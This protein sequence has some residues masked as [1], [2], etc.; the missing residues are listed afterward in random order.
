MWA[1]FSL[2]RK[3]LLLT[4]GGILLMGIA[5]LVYLT[6]SVAA[7]LRGELE[8]RG[9]TIANELA[10]RVQKPIID[11]DELTLMELV[12]ETKQISPD[13]AYVFILGPDNKPLA[14]TFEKFP[15]ELINKNPL[16]KGQPYRIE[17]IKTEAGIVRDVAVP[18]IG[19]ALG[20]VRLGLSE[21]VVRRTFM[22]TFFVILG[23]TVVLLI[24]GGIVSF[25][26]SRGITRPILHL[27]EAVNR[28]SL[29]ETD[30]PIEVKSKDEIGQLAEA[31]KR[32]QA[33]L[34]VAIKYLEERK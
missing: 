19:G 11:G 29:G 1:K 28:I 30:V 3:I 15:N 8:K 18:I 23:I 20:T 13:I 14:H 9:V 26:V 12:N 4:M 10:K 17:I 6:T 7:T 32:L 21:A 34:K 27:T 5:I 22:R 16:K 24:A 33:S 25:F 31:F 2:R